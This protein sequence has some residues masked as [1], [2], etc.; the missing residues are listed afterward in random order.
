MHPDSRSGC[1]ARPRR[2]RYVKV[3]SKIAPLKSSKSSNSDNRKTRKNPG[4][5]KRKAPENDPVSLGAFLANKTNSTVQITAGKEN[6]MIYITLRQAPRY[7]Q[8]TIEEFLFGTADTDA[9]D[10]WETSRVQTCT[11]TYAVNALSR[12]IAS[13]FD[14]VPM[15]ERLARFVRDT[16]ELR[17]NTAQFYE[18]FY[19]AKRDKGFT[20]VFRAMFESQDHF[21][22]CDSKTV[23]AA[24]KEMLKA[25]IARHPTTEHAALAE[26]TFRKVTDYLREQGFRVS[27]GS[28]EAWLK[29]GF[30]RI[31]APDQTLKA[32][33][34]E[35]KDILETDF[36]ALYHTSAYAYIQGRS[37]VDAIKRHQANESKWFAKLDLSDFFGSTTLPFV[38]RMLG[39][40][41]PFSEIM[42]TENGHNLLENALSLGF[43]DGRL[44]QGTPLSPML[45]NLMMIPIDHALANDLRDLAIVKN[46]ELREQRFIYTRY[47]DDFLISSRYDFDVRQI[48]AY[49][50]DTLARFE[51]PFTVNEDKTRYGSSSGRNFNLGMVLNRENRITVGHENK[52]IF[53]AMLTNYI[54]DNLNGIRWDKNRVRA[55][56]GL[57]N[58]YHMVEGQTFDRTVAHIGQKFSVDPRRMIL[59][60]LRQP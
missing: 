60:D 9:R 29:K 54:R 4:T 56:D 43:L 11:R 19:I 12:R 37:T 6:D 50:R 59:N 2:N 24:V 44:P 38:M 18:T 26:R 34:D 3:I 28:P 8:M 10:I 31:D 46:G 40:I 53:R 45:T 1:I 39:M 20:A 17:G 42:K 47:A 22:R 15:Q 52:H 51:A 13:R 32:R 30:R 49:V 25:L 58:Y 48:E 33:L 16:R 7:H 55:L 41:Y 21:V 23:C 35:L 5:E 36:G 57:R 14:P 27:S